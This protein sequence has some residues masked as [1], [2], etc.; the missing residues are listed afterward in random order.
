MKKVI[1]A[2]FL[3][4]LLVSC[5]GRTSRAELEAQ[6]AELSTELA[7][8][9]SLLND[10]FASLNDISSNLTAIKDREG[11]ITAAASPEIPNETRAQIS[12]DIAAI[13]E[14]LQQNR[15]SLERL[16]GATEQLRRANVRLGE[17]ETLI[18]NY[19]KQIADKDADIAE[20]RDA[21]ESMQ[22]QVA[23]LNISVE[24]LE[25]QSAALREE[26]QTLSEQVLSQDER[27]HTVYYIVGSD[28]SLREA[29]I[30]ERSSGLFSGASVLSDDASLEKFTRID[31]R[32]L[33]RIVV[34]R[35]RASIAT[36]HPAGSYRLVEEGNV[37]QEVVITDPGR[38]W[39][40]SKVLVI[41]YK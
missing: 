15:R 8:K 11:I 5:T 12:Q 32:E 21:L 36:S 31:S 38:F 13:D 26:R 14:L 20:L 40:T 9:D 6:S 2:L 41:S 28:R 16:Q 37:L 10:V 19:T 24:T 29:G 34:G 7:S 39:E 4:V 30:L 18:A 17:L 23:E 1:T 22:I 25:G 35:R 3:G 27:L 33:D